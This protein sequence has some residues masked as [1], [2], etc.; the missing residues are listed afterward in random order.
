[1]NL[2]NTNI[3]NR[4]ENEDTQGWCHGSLIYRLE[5]VVISR[6]PGEDWLKKM[7]GNRPR[8]RRL[9][10]GREKVIDGTRNMKKTSGKVGQLKE[11]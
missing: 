10:R 5:V 8:P 11:P 2:T 6:K 1:M 7:K 3:H 9:C 4:Y